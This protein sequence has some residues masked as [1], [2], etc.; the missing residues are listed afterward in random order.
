LALKLE[1]LASNLRL[2]M[3]AMGHPASLPVLQVDIAYRYPPTDPADASL[4]NEGRAAIIKLPPTIPAAFGVS[5][6]TP[7]SELMRCVFNTPTDY[8]HNHNHSPPP[9]PPPLTPLTTRTT[10]TTAAA[11]HHQNY[12]SPLLSTTTTATATAIH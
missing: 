11:T 8:H 10:T 4:L 6:S 3:T 1:V 12:Q 2:A 9:P 5:P 7:M